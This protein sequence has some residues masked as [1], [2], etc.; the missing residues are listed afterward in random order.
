MRSLVRTMETVSNYALERTVMDKV[1]LGSGRA[2]ASL[3]R[4]TL[5]TPYQPAAQRDR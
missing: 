1:Q 5:V 4:R 2:S 3:A